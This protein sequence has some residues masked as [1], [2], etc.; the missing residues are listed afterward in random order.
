MTMW[1]SLKYLVDVA[2]GLTLSFSLLMAEP[3]IE[4]RNLV[5]AF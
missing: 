3:E 2:L 5:L 1:C 4:T